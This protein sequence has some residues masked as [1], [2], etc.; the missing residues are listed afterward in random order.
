MAVSIVRMHRMRELLTILTTV[1]G[2]CQSVCLS[3]ARAV[4][5]ACHVIRCSLH[6]MILASCF[7]LIAML[8]SNVLFFNV[9]LKTK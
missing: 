2:V 1:R 8:A 5:A 7:L 3:A 4:Y 6:Q 9:L